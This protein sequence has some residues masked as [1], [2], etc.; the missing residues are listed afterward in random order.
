MTNHNLIEK[1]RYYIVD[2]LNIVDEE[3]SER[4]FYAYEN[5]SVDSAEYSWAVKVLNR[6][7]KKIDDAIVSE[8]DNF[9]V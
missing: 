1:Y 5:S 2:I 4:A 7:A 9:I 8:R 3:V 6:I